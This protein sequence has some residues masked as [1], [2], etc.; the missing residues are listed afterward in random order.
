MKVD[1]AEDFSYQMTAPD[2][3]SSFELQQL[4][5]NNDSDAVIIFLEHASPILHETKMMMILVTHLRSDGF[6]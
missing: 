1:G 5:N 4:K 3:L 6:W 2:F